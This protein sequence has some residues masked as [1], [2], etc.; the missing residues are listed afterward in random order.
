MDCLD[1]SYKF[2]RDFNSELGLRM[3]LWRD[4]FMKDLKQLPGLTA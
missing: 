2:A 3:K 4:G 1:K